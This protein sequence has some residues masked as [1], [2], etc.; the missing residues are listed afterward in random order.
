MRLAASS[1]GS[2][3]LAA[4]RRTDADA[5]GVPTGPEAWD[6]YVERHPAATYL[7]T[8]AWAEHK[9]GTGWQP[10]LIVSGGIDRGIVGAQV[11]LRRVAPLPWPFAYAPRGPLADRWT[12]PHLEAWSGRVRDAAAVG[13]ELAR[14]S[15]LRMDP[16][17]EEGTGVDDAGGGTVE[18]ERALTDLGWLR[19]PDVQ[20]R[21]TRIIDL[22]A[23]EAALWHDLRKKW[24]QYVNKA[25]SN[26]VV[27]RDVDAATE[28]GA[29]P[30]FYRVMR[31]TSLRTGIPLRTEA[32]YR[33]LWVAFHRGGNSRLLFAERDGEVLAVL[34]LVSCGGRVVEPYGGMTAAGGETRANYLLKWEAIRSSR[35]RGGRSYDLW[36]LV[37]PGISHFKEGFGGR[38]VRYVGSWDLVLAPLG[39]RL[40]RAA[41]WGRRAARR[42]V[43]VARGRSIGAAGAPEATMPDA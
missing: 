21:T 23:D 2:P 36:G 35:E 11:L 34:L 24:R 4:D 38:Q 8:S 7:Q 26:D 37:H 12:V 29:F 25:R 22:G 18:F 32:V 40:F 20:P 15:V 33:E 10:Q 19:A 27:V 1:G 17:V 14:A 39:G 31:E 43:L 41:E 16:E 5:A 28:A 42:A 30:T 9:L 3:R 6:A 13:G